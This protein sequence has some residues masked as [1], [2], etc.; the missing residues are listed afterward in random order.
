VVRRGVPDGDGGW[1]VCWLRGDRVTAV[2]TVDRPRDLAQGKRLIT[3]ATA[4]D[5]ALVADAAV[6]LRAAARTAVGAGS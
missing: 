3:A 5:P 6:A 2:L 4:V 1:S